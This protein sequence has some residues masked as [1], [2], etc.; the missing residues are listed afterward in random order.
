[1][2]LKEL[3]LEE[4]KKSFQGWDFSYINDR[5]EEEPLPWDYDKIVRQYL[6][7]DYMLLDMGT[8]GGEYL[9]SLGHPYKN[10]CVTEG[11]PPNVELCM[12]K[13][14]PLGIEVKQVI[15]D[16][17]LPF[18]DNMFDMVINRHESFDVNEVHRLL[19]PNGL[20]I[21]Q[22]V[23]GKNNK[24]LSKFLID[25]FKEIVSS[26]FD[27]N[28]NV[29]LVQN[30]GFTILKSD[31]YFPYIRFFDIGALVYFAKIIE[32]EF[33]NFSVERCYEKLCQLQSI[34][35]KQGFVESREHRFIIVARKTQK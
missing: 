29:E 14:E 32:W 7:P 1:M 10:T 8:G 30:A 23:G 5:T 28:N 27:L 22:Q 16:S 19:K 35:E 4:E 17:H 31:E 25:D 24:E 13:L 6:N 2:G 11:Y 12:E 9:L 20:F 15:D 26:N 21:T 34:L 3:W 33:P 18:D